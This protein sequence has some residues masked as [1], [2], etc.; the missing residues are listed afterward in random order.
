MSGVLEMVQV[1]MEPKR[2]EI[3]KSLLR[4]SKYIG[5]V[6]E[7]T[8]LDRATVAY[9]LSIL[10]DKHVVSSEYKILVPP[11]PVGKAAR[12]YS[13]NIELYREFFNNLDSVLPELKPK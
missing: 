1:I 10:E 2:A 12:V 7:D 8:K 13:I 5:Q 6:A 11:H 4:S 3:L 9:H